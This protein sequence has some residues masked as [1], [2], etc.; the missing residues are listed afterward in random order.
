MSESDKNSKDIK[1]GEENKVMNPELKK[2]LNERLDKIVTVNRLTL[3]SNGL[4]PVKKEILDELKDRP[5]K[6]NIKK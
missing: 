3:D 2:L 1:K 6:R 5:E 4:P